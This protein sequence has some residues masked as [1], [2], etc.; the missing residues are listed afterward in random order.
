MPKEADQGEGGGYKESKKEGMH[1]ASEEAP[2]GEK[3]VDFSYTEQ[4]TRL[5]TGVHLCRGRNT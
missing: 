4:Q 1:D 2:Q 5:M 3:P